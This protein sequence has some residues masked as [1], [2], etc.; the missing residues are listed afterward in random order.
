MEELIAN[1]WR[2]GKLALKEEH[3]FIAALKLLLIEVRKT[4][5]NS[6]P[7]AKSID[8]NDPSETMAKISKE[9]N[10]IELADILHIDSG[11]GNRKGER[12][13]AI[14]QRKKDQRKVNRSVETNLRKITR[15]G[16]G[17]RNPWKVRRIR[18]TP[19]SPF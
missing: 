15:R 5:D 3:I 12:R 2:N 7:L 4:L 14:S 9:E 10:F 13:L 19:L 1:F 6:S 11:R 18:D 8:R 16:S 17:R